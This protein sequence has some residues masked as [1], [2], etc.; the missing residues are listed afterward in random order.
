MEEGGDEYKQLIEDAKPFT[1]EYAVR[2][3]IGSVG[4]I[5]SRSVHPE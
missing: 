4:D 2:G 1:A 3:R 5:T